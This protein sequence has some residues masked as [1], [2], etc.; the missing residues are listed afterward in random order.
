MFIS[1]SD[2]PNARDLM[3]ALRFLPEE[4]QIWLGEQRMLLMPLAASAFFRNEL[5]TTLGMER[6]GASLCAWDITQD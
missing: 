6:A 3:D 2:Y 4:G 5:I 1:S